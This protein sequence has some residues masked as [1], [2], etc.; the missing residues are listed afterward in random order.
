MINKTIDESIA[1]LEKAIDKS[2]K[3][4]N[5]LETLLKGA[6]M[7]MKMAD[8]GEALINDIEY[9]LNWKMSLYQAKVEA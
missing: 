9:V 6:A 2:N 7:R 4:I 3:Y 1:D 8:I 5:Q